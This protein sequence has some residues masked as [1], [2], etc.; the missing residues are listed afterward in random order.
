[1]SSREI[2][3][4]G[5]ETVGKG[6]RAPAP[7]RGIR[8]VELAHWMAGPAA[9]GLL[10]DWGAEVIKVEAPGGDPM[11][12]VF[13][14]MGFKPETPNG[15]FISANRGKKSVAI[16]IRTGPGREVFDRLLEEA[17]VLLTNLRPSALKRLGLTPE[18]VTNRYPRLVYCSLTAY[19][20]GGPDQERP[21]YDL[22]AFFGRAGVSHQITTRGTPPA[23]LM[24]GMGDT[25]TA[26]SAASGILAALVERQG[27]GKGRFVEASLL[28]TGMWALGGVLGVKAMG[29]NP[30]PPARREVCPTP[31]YNSY[32]AA[33]DRW[34]FLVG[35][36]GSR[37][38]PNVLAAIGRTDLLDDERFKDER[39]LSKNRGE[40]IAIFDEAFATKPLHEWIEIFDQHDVWWAPVQTPAEVIEDPQARAVGAWIEVEQ[41]SS[42]SV[43]ESVDSPIRFDG[44]SRTKVRGAPEVGEQTR[45]V[46][47][48]LG[49]SDEQIEGLVRQTA[50]WGNEGKK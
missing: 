5:L 50:E 24:Q 32:R 13:G 2:R 40:V 16:E 1:M 39:S 38:I 43:V 49:Y 6:G 25:F 45:Q 30:R 34:F 17:D 9:G 44:C 48:S 26:L 21:G 41:G 28:R 18:A 22:A 7:L 19:G 12:R 36:E 20:W 15:A 8:V 3:P 23:T 4:E 29:G 47:S 27:T 31:L 35:V 42:G 14:A 11:R 33:D 10:S 46:L 37:H